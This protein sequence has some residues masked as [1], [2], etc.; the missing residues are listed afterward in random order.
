MS[1]CIAAMRLTS[2]DMRHRWSVPT[3][4]LTWSTTRCLPPSPRLADARSTTN[5]KTWT[6]GQFPAASGPRFGGNFVDSVV[7]FGDQFLASGVDNGHASTWITS[8]GNSWSE[9]SLPDGIV[10]DTQISTADGV[11]VSG[12]RLVAM[13]TVFSEHYAGPGY[14]SDTGMIAATG[15]QVIAAWWSNDGLTWT[16]ADLPIADGQPQQPGPIAGGP[17]GFVGMV[18]VWEND[19][20]VESSIVS[21]DG[22]H[23]DVALTPSEG[24]RRAIAATDHGWV[25]VGT[26]IDYFRVGPDTEVLQRGPH[27][28]SVWI[29]R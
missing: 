13:G 5:G 10:D 4:L 25:A 17:A 18:R 2:L 8:D 15:S 11:A 21:T 20:Y 22:Q 16:R 27:N 24:P 26:D 28:A 3:T 7:T 19:R 9:S 29:A 14:S 23:W 1:I 6:R 12:G